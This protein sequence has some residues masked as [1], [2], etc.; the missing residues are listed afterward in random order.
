NYPLSKH[1]CALLKCRK[2]WVKISSSVFEEVNITL[3]VPQGTILGLLF[4]DD[5]LL[6]RTIRI[7]ND[8]F[9]LH[10]DIDTLSNG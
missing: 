3:G 6:Y 9:V 8:R 1:I 4:A 5:C 7:V 10:N 2:Q